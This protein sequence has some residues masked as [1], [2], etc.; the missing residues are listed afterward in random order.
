[1]VG[2]IERFLSE[3]HVRLD[4]L[5][6]RADRGDGTIDTVAYGLFRRGLLRHIAMEEKVLLPFAR[7]KRGEPLA[8]AKRLRQD[9]G[10]IASLLVP[11]PTPALCDRLRAKL[12]EHNALEEGERGLYAE[13]DAL[14]GPEVA[15]VLERLRAQPEVPVAPHY[16]G[17]LLPK[18]AR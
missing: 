18:H 17:P 11:S 7:E 4:A 13:C 5:L 9:H 1:M 8:I 12:A 3:D 16:D 6:T 10:E 14:A 15:R 2:D